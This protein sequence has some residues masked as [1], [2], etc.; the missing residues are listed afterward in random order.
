VASCVDS[1]GVKALATASFAEDTDPDLDFLVCFLAFGSAAGSVGAT[2]ASDSFVF[3]FLDPT[4][5][6]NSDSM[7]S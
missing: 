3:G 4:S 5:D 6:L 2:D 7:G 1:V